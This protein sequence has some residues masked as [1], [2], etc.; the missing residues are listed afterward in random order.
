MK[1]KKD[2]IF[3]HHEKTGGT[4]IATAI[5]GGHSTAVVPSD[6]SYDNGLTKHFSVDKMKQTIG[7]LKWEQSV[8]FTV[9]RNPWDR[10]VSKWCWRREGM[11]KRGC[12]AK[13]LKRHYLHL[14][15]L[16][17]IPLKWFEQEIKEECS[18]WQLQQVDDFIFGANNTPPPFQHILRFETLDE[19]W[20]QLQHL[21][22]FSSLPHINKTVERHDYHTY[23]NEITATF[24]AIQFSRTITC[25]AYTF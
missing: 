24:V 12:G 19:D 4:S 2:F 11:T 18:R 15:A 21:Y 23:Y 22:G 3:V 8:R 13:E 25:F 9:V 6:K 20:K 14:D 17:H 7:P 1:P 16:G 10:L 5:E